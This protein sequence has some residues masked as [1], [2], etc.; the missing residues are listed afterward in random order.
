MDRDATMVACL[1]VNPGRPSDSFEI[2]DAEGM[3]AG[4]RSI[5]FLMT[6]SKWKTSSAF[7]QEVAY[8]V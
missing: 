7:L 2:V 8:A 4:M 3:V 5:Q 6:L 1:E